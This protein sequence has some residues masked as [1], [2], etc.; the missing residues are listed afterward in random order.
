MSWP[1]TLVSYKRTDVFTEETVP[2]GLTAR[3]TTKEGVWALIRVLEGELQF[4]LEG[5][6]PEI[7][8]RSNPGLVEPTVPHHIEVIGPV[9]FYVEFFRDA[10]SREFDDD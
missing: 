1:S 3:H 9:R 2:K 4:Q 10:S 7:L 6:M 8:S 5:E